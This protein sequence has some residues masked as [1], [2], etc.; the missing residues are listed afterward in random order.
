M[1]TTKIQPL[2][3]LL[4]ALAGAGALFGV[5][6]FLH[7]QGLL[8]KPGAPAAGTSASA[9][10]S[11]SPDSSP[12]AKRDGKRIVIGVNDFGG[13]YPGVVANDGSAPG[14]NSVFTKAGLDVEIR[15]IRGS[16]ERLD[17]FDEGKVDIMLLSLDYFAN[18][19]PTYAEKGVK[20]KA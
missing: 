8:G 10:S 6:W 15:L 7:G 1:A 20:L 9:D 19:V 18:L 13:A 12:P 11:G 5:I 4:I 17:A 2:G 3:K 14:P 16:K